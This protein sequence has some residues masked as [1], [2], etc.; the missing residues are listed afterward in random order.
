[1]Y[2]FLTRM[3]RMLPPEMAHHAAIKMLRIFPAYNVIKNLDASIFSQ[4]LMG[5]KF[6]HPLGLAAGF[7]KDAEV[8]DKLGQL[9]FS[10]I[11]VGSITPRAQPGNPKPRLFRLSD[12]QAIINR[13]GFNSKGL[14]YVTNNLQRYPRTCTVG[15]NL[16]KNKNTINYVDDFLLGAE[17]LAKYAD[18]FTINVSSPNTPGLRDLQTSEA[19]DPVIDGVRAIFRSQNRSVPLLIKISPDLNLYQLTSLV[20]FLLLKTVD[21]IIVTNTTT[22]REGIQTSKFASEQGG[23]S[24]QPLKN[25]STEMLRSVFNITRGKI[26]LIGCGGISSGQDAYEKLCAGANLLQLYTSF[27]FQGP[28]VIRRILLELRELLETKGVKNIQEI[29]GSNSFL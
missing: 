14:D 11:E 12:Q 3:L 25:R 9:G 28:L 18:Y 2:Q 19:L 1:M 27:I 16:G 26:T 15:I 22:S 5:M 8:F 17:A 24:G 23:L 21:G 4:Q 20:E 10:F 13:Y 6:V 29:I 7:D